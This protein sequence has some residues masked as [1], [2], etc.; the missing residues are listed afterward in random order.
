MRIVIKYN[1]GITERYVVEAFAIHE[2]LMIFVTQDTDLMFFKENDLW[3]DHRGDSN[4]VVKSVL[5]YA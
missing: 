4:R 1:D 3:I 5:S 2:Y